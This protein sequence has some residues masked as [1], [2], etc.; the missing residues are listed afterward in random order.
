MQAQ[1]HH[2][3]PHGEGGGDHHLEPHSNMKHYH[4]G[5]DSLEEGKLKTPRKHFSVKYLVYS[6][7]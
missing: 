3:C 2:K 1:Y 7:L 6:V 5:N 4:Q